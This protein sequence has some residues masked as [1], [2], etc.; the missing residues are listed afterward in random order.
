[1]NSWISLLKHECLTAEGCK[2]VRFLV[3]N[4]TR[5]IR[6]GIPTPDEIAA[7]KKAWEN[8][9]AALL[10]RAERLR[11]L[12]LWKK[13]AWQTQQLILQRQVVDDVLQYEL[14]RDSDGDET[15]VLMAELEEFLR[16]TERLVLAIRDTCR[17]QDEDKA[18]AA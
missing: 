16:Q 1:M 9:H 10:T 15:L 2:M 6:A 18:L 11:L 8:N 17:P 3:Q 7:L 12:S 14:E 13:F 5:V 4:A